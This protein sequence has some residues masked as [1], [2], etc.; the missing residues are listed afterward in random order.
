MR[1]LLKC[2]SI[3][4]GIIAFAIGVS[5]SAWYFASFYKYKGDIDR[6]FALAEKEYEV[7]DREIY[8]LAVIAEGEDCFSRWAP[9]RAYWDIVDYRSKKHF[10][11]QLNWLLWYYAFQMHYDQQ[12]MFRLWCHYVVSPKGNGLKK[13][14]L[15]YFGKHIEALS[16]REKA[17]IV[18]MV[19]SPSRYAPGNEPSE[20]RVTDILERYK[21]Y[22]KN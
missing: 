8:Q 3:I 10:T 11:N 2:C 15:H 4:F 13:A 6:V 9:Q 16:L 22:G 17:A 14:A 18:A 20:Q 7:I 19:R 1:K 12:K 21:R 5:L